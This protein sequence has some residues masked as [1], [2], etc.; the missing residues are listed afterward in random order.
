MTSVYVGVVGSEVENGVCRDTIE[1]I[2]IRA[3]DNRP[4][5]IRSTKGFEGRQSHINF[6]LEKT[7]Y[8]AIL[9]LDSDMY[10]QPDTLERL[11]SHDKTYVSGYYMRRMFRPIAPVW[12]EKN[13]LEIWPQ[14]PWLGDPER[15]KLHELGGSGWG[16]MFVHRQVFEDMKPILKG[17]PYVIEDDMD[18]WPYD[19]LKVCTAVNELQDCDD[20]EEMKKHVAILRE[21]I[22]PLTGNRGNVGSDVRFPFFARQAGHKLWGDPDVR[23]GHNLQYPLTPDDYTMGHEQQAKLT[24]EMK[25]RHDEERKKHEKFIKVLRGEK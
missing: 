18:I 13:E 2:N 17:E 23:P 4:Q 11:R 6:F 14:M 19:I 24:T 9:L 22:R 7:T 10:F 15:G 8:D 1:H 25:E 5:Y 16:C 20:L 3:G 12:Y 21:E